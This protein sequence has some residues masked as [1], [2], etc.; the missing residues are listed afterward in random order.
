MI[1][2]YVHVVGKKTVIS[3]IWNKELKGDDQVKEMTW[4]LDWS[5]EMI[6]SSTILD[7][8][9]KVTIEGGEFTC[10]YQL[11]GT[12]ISMDGKPL[13]AKYKIKAIQDPER[14]DASNTEF[15]IPDIIDRIDIV[16]NSEP[17]SDDEFELTHEEN[18][19]HFI[20]DN[21]KLTV[22][23]DDCEAFKWRKQQPYRTDGN[24]HS[25]INVMRLNDVYFYI[26]DGVGFMTTNNNLDF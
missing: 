26:R 15:N 3:S 1:K 6:T 18:R 23:G 25:S 4:S 17:F 8:V 24:T 19:H 2:T 5:P 22:E 13:T 16:D 10:E 21:L 7:R 9:T 14:I 12:G 11:T 20:G